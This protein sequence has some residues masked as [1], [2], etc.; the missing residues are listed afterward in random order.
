M[1]F[2]VNKVRICRCGDTPL[3]QSGFGLV[4]QHQGPGFVVLVL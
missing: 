4:N 1:P 3:H 2:A